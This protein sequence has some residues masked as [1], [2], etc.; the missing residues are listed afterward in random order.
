MTTGSAAWGSQL[1]GWQWPLVPGT[2]SSKFGT[3]EAGGGEVKGHEDTQLSPPL[4]NFFKV[5]LRISLLYPSCYSHQAF[6][7][8][9]SGAH[10]EYAFGRQYQGHRGRELPH[11]LLW[12]PLS[13]AA[14]PTMSK[15]NWPLPSPWQAQQASS[16]RP[17]AL[18]FFP[19]ELQPLS[20]PGGHRVLSLMTMSLAAQGP[21]P[22]LHAFS[23]FL[24]F[25]SL[26]KYLQ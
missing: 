17:Q 14:S 2:A 12:P 20:R 15:D 13:M 6:S 11:L 26:L 9:D 3:E 5:P 19:P 1:M 25:S 23:F 21:G 10:G 7:F 16:V 24:P 4:P 8:E 22:L 18:G